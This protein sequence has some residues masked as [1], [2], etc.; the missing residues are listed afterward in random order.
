MHETL[1]S[2]VYGYLDY[3]KV[4]HENILIRGWCFHK[5]CGNLPIRLNHDGVLEHKS[6]KFVLEQRDDVSDFYKNTKVTKCGWIISMENVDLLDKFSIEMKIN[7]KWETVFDL[8][9]YDTNKTYIPS[10]V[11]VDDFYKN[12]DRVREYALKQDFI[13]HPNNHKG[14]RTDLVY[15][16][17][18]LKSRFE[19]ILGCKIKN[20][21]KY[22]VNCC[23][24]SCIAGDQLVYHI[25]A[26]QYA[27]VLFLT[28]DAPP[29]AGTTF[30]RSK[31]T[32]TIKPTDE[33]YNT[34]FKNGFYDP[35]Q[36]DIVDVVG[37]R[38]NRIVLFD[39][40]MIHAA[41]SYFGNEI[42]NGRLFQMFFFDLDT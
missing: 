20:W 33:N 24:Q 9:F 29:E 41:S 11:V 6:E 23:F 16:F 4:N 14:K 10:F 42:N 32:K 5:T 7:D 8:L 17:P 35:S 15:R 26:Q 18:N 30:F 1:V 12:P 31:T 13:E 22:G 3:Y 19:T 21:E 39:A 28:P 37:N 40:Q 38:Y 27:G 25:D 34:I 36:F 2:D